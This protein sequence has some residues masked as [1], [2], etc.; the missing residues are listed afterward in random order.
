[1]RIRSIICALLF[2]PTLAMAGAG[3][4]RE[5]NWP[6]NTII[7]DA[8]G[9]EG[10]RTLLE[11]VTLAQN[12]YTIE[13]Y[14]GSYTA[15]SVVTPAGEEYH[16][17][18]VSKYQTTI[19]N[20]GCLFNAL[21]TLYFEGI[22]FTQTTT[23]TAFYVASGV[24]LDFT[25]CH[26]QLT[27]QTFNRKIIAHE[28]TFASRG[29]LAFSNNADFYGCAFQDS[30]V[31]FSG[32]GAFNF[33]EGCG[34]VGTNNQQIIR[35]VNRPTVNF[36]GEGSWVTGADT[37]ASFWGGTN[38]SVY[39]GLFKNACGDVPAFYVADSAGGLFGPAFMHNAT[40][41]DT[42]EGFWAHTSG[43]L[44]FDGLRVL[45]AAVVDTVTDLSGD[46]VH[47][48][49]IGA[50][51]VAKRTT[52][53]GGPNP[54]GTSSWLQNLDMTNASQNQD[55]YFGGE[56][57]TKGAPGCMGGSATLPVSIHFMNSSNQSTGFLG[58]GGWKADDQIFRHGGAGTTVIMAHHHAFLTWNVGYADS[59]LDTLWG[60]PT[61]VNANDSCWAQIS[62]VTTGGTAGAA[63]P[64]I[65]Y[66]MGNDTLFLR[67]PTTGTSGQKYSID[68]WKGY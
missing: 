31:T 58:P 25:D 53:L 14:A 3:L 64:R 36:Y 67:K 1:M 42:D 48:V 52:M 38:V 28:T 59:T 45:D 21:D 16:F 32:T 10:V 63:D 41:N 61:W 47:V 39:G 29:S 56:W 5:F 51:L 9:K 15:D 43:T 17:K 26:L 49:M 22:K 60:L 18:G 24:V 20:T 19:T 37:C 4:G 50:G 33:Y 2:L 54:G 35:F 11:A 55:H 62:M 27:T 8:T 34:G 23:S 30:T 46:S 13:I 44:T 66:T 68:I 12:G 7:V 65:S 6:S 57:I 40:G